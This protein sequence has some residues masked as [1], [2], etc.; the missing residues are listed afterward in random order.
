MDKVD[1]WSTTHQE[2]VVNN[3]S[4]KDSNDTKTKGRSN[5]DQDKDEYDRRNGVFEPLTS[6]NSHDPVK[7]KYI[8]YYYLLF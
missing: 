6:S 1:N 2:V 8:Y 3:S 5:K 7:C 4:Y